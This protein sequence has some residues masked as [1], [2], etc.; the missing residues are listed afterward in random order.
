MNYILEFIKIFIFINLSILSKQD[1]TKGIT[2]IINNVECPVFFNANDD[3]L[4]IISSGNIYVV[5][6]DDNSIKHQKNITR[7][8]SGF[9]LYIDKL[10]NYYFLIERI[11]YKVLLNETMKFLI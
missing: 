3:C 5:N 1:I 7:Y 8:L 10:N 11:R 2:Q 9:L 6:K 4:N